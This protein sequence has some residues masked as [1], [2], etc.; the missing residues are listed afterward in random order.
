MKKEIQ[1]SSKF[2]SFSKNCT[3]KFAFNLAKSLKPPYVLYLNGTLGS[4]KT[5]F[6]Q[7]IGEYY[8][9]KNINSASFCRTTHNF[10]EINLIHC[11]FYRGLPEASFF[12]EEIEPLLISPWIILIEWGKP[13]S[14]DFDCPKYELDFEYVDS[15]RRDLLFCKRSV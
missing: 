3:R 11:D 8:G 7:C 6:C 4:G 15:T 13:I 10:G 14:W 12:E 2:R 1:D 5:F 9:I